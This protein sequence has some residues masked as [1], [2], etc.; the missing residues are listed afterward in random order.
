MSKLN[1]ILI[2]G[3]VAVV[4]FTIY[5]EKNYRS[6][7]KYI[8][9][10][11]EEIIAGNENLKIYVGN[12][13]P[14][15]PLVFKINELISSYE[16]DRVKAF[17]EE[18]AR[19]QMLSNLSHDVRTPLT[20]VLGYLDALCSGMAGEESEE[21]LHIAKN[22]AYELKDYIDEL[23]TVV[24]IDANELQLTFKQVDLFELLRRESIGWIPLLKKEDITLEVEI[25]DEE[26]FVTIDE[27]GVIRIFNNLIQ[28]ALRY[29]GSSKYIGIFAWKDNSNVYFKVI[30]KGPGLSEE[31]ISR[32]FKRLY[33]KDSS[34]STKGHG[35]GLTITKELVEKMNGE[36]S[37][38]SV[39]YT[40]TYV[41]VSLPKSK[42][43]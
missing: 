40:K 29:G 22:K 9:K 24:Q 28:N 33:R 38:E 41:Q 42:K 1:I 43:K 39:P 30:D 23:F 14:I 6:N 7:T 12:K 17:R 16:K 10:V 20:S 25:P 18:Q 3:L 26:S 2:I 35:L 36:I 21:Y 5:R 27:H 34:R 32:A 4:A 19:K 31:E 13:D 15:A 11:L 37:M 8:L